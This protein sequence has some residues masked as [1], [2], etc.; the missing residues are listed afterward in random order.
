MVVVVVG[1]FENIH[2]GLIITAVTADHNMALADHEDTKT[3]LANSEG[4]DN[5]MYSRKRNNWG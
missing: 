4:Q 5:L 1:L 2:S 3:T